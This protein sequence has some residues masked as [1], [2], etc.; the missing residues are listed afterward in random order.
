MLLLR[1]WRICPCCFL[2]SGSGRQYLAFLS[3]QPQLQ[4]SILRCPH[5]FSPVLLS[6]PRFSLSY[7]APVT[8]DQ[9]PTFLQY[10]LVL[11]WLHQQ[12]TLF[13]N[14]VTFTGARSWDFDTSFWGMQFKPHQAHTR[15]SQ[16]L[17][18]LNQW[19][20]SLPYPRI[21]SNET[22]LPKHANDWHLISTFQ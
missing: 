6:V 16:H 2:V 19:L 22:K 11:T 21:Q 9:R 15:F 17:S 5:V 8:L 20:F 10:D 7:R 3:L 4:P 18:V 14:E 12:K 1:L 13:P